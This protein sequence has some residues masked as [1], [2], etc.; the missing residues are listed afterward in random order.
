LS[1]KRNQAGSLGTEAGGFFAVAIV[2][3]MYTGQS[4]ETAQTICRAPAVAS[5]LGNEDENVDLDLV[6]APCQQAREFRD[7]GPRAWAERVSG[8]DQ[9]GP[10]AGEGN[11]ARARPMI[12]G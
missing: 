11:P 3:Q 12:G 7:A 4:A 1:V 8:H 9:R 2:N 5:T 6:L 10:A